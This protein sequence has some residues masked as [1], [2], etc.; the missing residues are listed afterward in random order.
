MRSR[1]PKFACEYCYWVQGMGLAGVEPVGPS[2]GAF[3]QACQATSPPAVD[4]RFPLTPT[5]R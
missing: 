5:L 1:L 3:S 4:L 2:E